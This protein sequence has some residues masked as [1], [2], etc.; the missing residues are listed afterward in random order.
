MKA[1]NKISTYQNNPQ[2]YDGVETDN[3]KKPFFT[4]TRVLIGGIALGALGFGAY[5]FFEWMKQNKNGNNSSD[6]FNAGIAT[7]AGTFPVVDSPKNNTGTKPPSYSPTPASDF[8]LKKGSRGEKVRQ[9]QEALI[10]KFG[11]SL[12]PKY[13]ADGQ[14]G[15]EL[16]NALKAKGLPATIGEQQFAILTSVD[17]TDTATKIYNALTK[18]DFNATVSALKTLRDTNDYKTVGDQFK[19]K[20]F[21]GVST[22][23]VTGSLNTFSDPSQKQQIQ[24]EFSRMGLKYD[25][26]KWSIPEGV[27]GLP[28]RQIIATRPT[29]VWQNAKHALA[30]GSNVVLGREIAS[31]GGITL[32]DTVDG[33]R[34][35][36]ITGH[37]RYM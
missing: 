21:N 27:S 33:F 10:A 2:Y 31:S 36:V 6:L 7:D 26:T 11:K 13:G 29:K 4:P 16:E 37:V 1:N 18:K 9:L 8:P 34:L 5:K 3:E 25:G 22:T 30:V 19:A 28:A 17:T 35:Y 32:F 20:R 12:M 23:L 14:F 24:L 15:S